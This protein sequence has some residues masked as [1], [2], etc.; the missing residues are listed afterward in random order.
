MVCVDEDP[1]YPFG[2][3]YISTLPLSKAIPVESVASCATLFYLFVIAFGHAHNKEAG[4]FD[5]LPAVMAAI[6]FQ[7]LLG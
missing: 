1:L 5:S 4:E 2:W 7:D 3:G 6:L